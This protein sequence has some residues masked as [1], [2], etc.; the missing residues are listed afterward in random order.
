MD[1]SIL[2]TVIV[3][4]YNVEQWIKRCI[5]SIL[6]QT[7]RNLE[8]IVI[9]D[10][11]TDNTAKLLDEFALNDKRIV[12]IHQ[13]NAGLVAVREKGISLAKGD[14]VGFVDGDDVVEPDMYERLLRNA[15]EYDA[16][17]SHCGIKYCFYDGR[18]KLHYGTGIVKVF[19][20]DRGVRELLS[21][22]IIEPSLCNKLYKKEILYNSCLDTTVVNYE[23]LLRNFV[24]F[25]RANRSVYE[26]FC[27]YQ[28][29]RRDNS[30][31][32]NSELARQFKHIIYAKSII[33]AN[34][35]DIF[36][37]DAIRS[38]ISTIV[39]CANR[40]AFHKDKESKK[41]YSECR[42]I[43]KDNKRNILKLTNRQK[44]AAYLIL[45]CPIMHKK[46][47]SIYLKRK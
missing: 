34:S 27:A 26:D 38:W 17:I 29:W 20:R 7:Y 30:M 39:N 14:Y 10:G 47:Y 6:N 40:L 4:A 28:Y 41:L 22:E 33:V 18:V 19:N 44:V 15:L 23:D 16:E 12:I 37:S 32:N 35:S 24:L 21:S 31:S 8:V 5:N 3:P 42:K 1:T 45:F 13:N 9:D 43:L 36:R 46:I 11:S 2:L 25:Q